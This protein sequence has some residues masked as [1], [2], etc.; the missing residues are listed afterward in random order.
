MRKANRE[1]TDP[2][3][4][5]AIMEEAQVCRLGMCDTGVPYIVPMN[6][7]LGENCLYFHCAPEGK[8]ID[9]LRDNNRVCFE[10]DLLREVKRGAKACDFSARYESVIGFGRA[11]LVEGPDEKRLALDRI[12]AH[13]GAPGP[14]TYR[15]DILAKTTVVRIDIDSLTGK[16]H[17]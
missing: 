3:K 10:M 5:R 13:Y 12:M 17:E 11:I 9:I 15:D 8:K 14:H 1:I 4:V 6:F 16:R 7:G 2:G